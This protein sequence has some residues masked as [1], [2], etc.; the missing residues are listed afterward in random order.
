[1]ASDN[2]RLYGP[3]IGYGRLV[4]ARNSPNY[5]TIPDP[6]SVIYLG[7]TRNV[8]LMPASSELVD[9]LEPHDHMDTAV[10]GAGYGV[11]GV[12]GGGVYPGWCSRVGT[13]EGL[14]RVLTQ[15]A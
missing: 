8:P 13:G 10:D 14:Y 7:H 1:M 11:S 12:H 3:R 6:E 5:S 9:G 15:P 4:V 2:L